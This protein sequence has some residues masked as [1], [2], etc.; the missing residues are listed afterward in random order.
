MIACLTVPIEADPTSSKN[1]RL[2]LL[3]V[4][5]PPLNTHVLKKYSLFFTYFIHNVFN[6]FIYLFL[7][8][9]Y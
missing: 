2:S 8:R 1:G 7:N 6:Y 4:E 5:L 3:P 9:K